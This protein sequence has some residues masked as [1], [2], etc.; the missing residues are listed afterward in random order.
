MVQ[1]STPWGD[2]NRGMGP[3]WGAF[4]QITLTS[5]F[6][7]SKVP[8]NC[9]ST[10]WLVAHNSTVKCIRD[11]CYRLIG[12]LTCGALLF[13]LPRNM[14]TTPKSDKS[15]QA[16]RRV[17]L[18]ESQLSSQMFHCFDI[19]TVSSSV[20]RRNTGASRKRWRRPRTWRAF[21]SRSSGDRLLV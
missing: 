12:T 18:H 20:C 14:R 16:T 1:L 3:P 7:L 8:E 21:R 17:T 5:C 11:K 9:L 13:Q 6:V 19:S 4:C 15:A 10:M 2:P